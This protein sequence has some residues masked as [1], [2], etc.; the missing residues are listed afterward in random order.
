[1]I[2]FI[3]DSLPM[4]IFIALVCWAVIFIEKNKKGKP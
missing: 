2:D 1:M 3:I 4:V